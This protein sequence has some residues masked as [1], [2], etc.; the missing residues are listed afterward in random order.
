MKRVLEPRTSGQRELKVIKV[1]ME[2]SWSQTQSFKGTK[3][4]NMA[5]VIFLSTLN[6]ELLDAQTLFVTRANTS[7]SLLCWPDSRCRV[8]TIDKSTLRP[9]PSKDLSRPTQALAADVGRP[10]VQKYRYCEL[11]RRE[12][13]GFL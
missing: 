8:Y 9:R 2:I 3:L 5:A 10:S 13:S 7:E 11:V 6:R 4:S 1:E 12:A